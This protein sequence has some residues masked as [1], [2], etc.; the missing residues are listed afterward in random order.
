MG[1]LHKEAEKFLSQPVFFSNIFPTF[2]A[3]ISSLGICSAQ[4]EF[5]SFGNCLNVITKN[6]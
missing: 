6:I 1:L 5:G 2:A 3:Q 4:S